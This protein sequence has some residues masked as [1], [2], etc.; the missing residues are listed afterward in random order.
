MQDIWD[1]KKSKLQIMDV[2]EEEEMQVKAITC[3]V[4]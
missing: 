1:I 4:K 2:E 3:S